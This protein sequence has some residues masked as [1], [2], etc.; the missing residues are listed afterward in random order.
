MSGLLRLFV[1]AAC[2][3]AVAYGDDWAQWRGPARTGYVPAGAAVPSEL[4]AAPKVLWRMPLTDGVSSPV[5]AGGKV[6]CLDNQQGK[7]S[8]HAFDAGTGKVLWSV[9]LDEVHKDTQSKPGPRC[10]PL[11]DGDRV[12]AQSC[13]GELKCLALADGKMVWETNYVKDFGATFIGEKGNAPGATRHGYDGSPLIDG[14]HLIAEVGGKDGA[15]IVCFD[16]LN[17]KV[18]WKSQNDTPA[19]AAPIISTIDGVR[20]LIAFMVEG[21]MAIDPVD[22]KFLWRAPVKTAL[23]RH[24]TTPVVVGNMVLVASHQAGLLGIKVDKQGDGFK[25]VQVWAAKESA[26]NFSSPVAVGDYLYGLGPNKNLICV[27]VQSGKQTWS[28]TGYSGSDGGHAHAGMIVMGQNL[29]V[30]M[31]NGQ[32]ALVAADPKAYHEVS[33]AQVC[34]TNWCNP[35]YADGKLYFRDAR[36]L[37]CVQLLP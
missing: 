18:I 6:I 32:L 35:A 15:A 12:Y 11:V 24:V 5:V 37:W 8:V 28:K 19:Y 20:Q 1:C 34:G 9:D 13:R 3:C 10:T 31:D 7:E 29:L 2:V 25:G 16:K 23:G 17:G 21:V 27:D 30:L 4:P 36:E 22:G 14:G 26:I 33:R